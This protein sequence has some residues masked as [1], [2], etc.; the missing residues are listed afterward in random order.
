MSNNAALMDIGT[1]RSEVGSYA[2]KWLDFMVEHHLDL[3]WEMTKSETL[4]AVA[5]SVDDTAWEYRE[6]LDAQYMKQNP[7]P[8]TFEEIVKWETTRMFYTDWQVMREKVLI[9]ITAA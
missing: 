5:Q 6:L 7:R 2:R 1:T 8:K 9:P 4:E 3:A